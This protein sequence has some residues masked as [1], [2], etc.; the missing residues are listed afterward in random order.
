MSSEAVEAGTQVELR[1]VQL[2]TRKSIWQAVASGDWYEITCKMRG[3]SNSVLWGLI[4]VQGVD[5]AVSAERKDAGWVCLCD[6][7]SNFE[8]LIL[9]DQTATNYCAPDVLLPPLGSFLTKTLTLIVSYL[10]VLWQLLE[11]LRAWFAWKSFLL[12]A[13]CVLATHVLTLKEQGGSFLLGLDY[14]EALQS[15]H[16]LRL[17]CGWTWSL[18]TFHAPKLLSQQ[19]LVGKACKDLRKPDS[20]LS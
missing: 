20:R 17:P 11:H 4:Y 8:L 10:S 2:V 12:M 9:D 6:E 7:I 15:Q 5:K 3:M 13:M 1:E 18:A 19:L 14:E 16:L